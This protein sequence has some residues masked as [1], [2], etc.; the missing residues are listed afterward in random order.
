M[1][2]LN[3]INGELVEPAG[4]GWLE[5]VEPATGLVY[6]RLP[7]SDERDVERA[8]SA[9]CEAFGN[10]SRTPPAARSRV[11]VRLADLIE[12]NL[13]DLARAESI[14]T[15]K[16]LT[17]ARAV[18]I[19]RAAANLRFFATA[20]LHQRSDLHTSD[21]GAPA[22]Q[23][24][25]ALNYTLRQPLGAVG[26][27]SPWNL[28]LYLFTW[29]VAPALAAGNT[30][31]GKPSEL[32]PATAHRL[33]EMA[34]EAGLP[35][36]VLNI[37]HGLGPKTGAAITR[38]PAISAISFTGGTA[39]GAQVA[40]EVSPT[41]R[42]LSLELGG[43]N[44]TIVFADADLKAALAGSTLA[45]FAN[46]G[47][48]CLCGSRILVEQPIYESFLDGL[49]ERARSLRV[50]D[51]LCDS[52]KVG[53]LVSAAHLAKVAGYLDLA[54]REGGAVHCGGPVA[55]DDL[56]PRCR[57]GF[58]FAPAVISGL[59]PD[60]RT[61]CEEIFGPIVTVQPFHDETEA[62]EMANATDY[63]L[64]ASVWTR[65]V[66]RAHRVAE[67]VEAGTVWINCWL[68]RDLRV[69]FGGV[70]KSGV[71]REGGEEALRFFTEAKNVCVALDEESTGSARS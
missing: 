65:H 70:K 61:N 27:I 55:P 9:A 36:G 48:I 67:R 38:H 71:G 20:I 5:N 12:R 59:G 62:V 39:T 57:G 25:R 44:P 28:P 23:G 42:K 10:W 19:P 63:G 14:D 30:V 33:A 50:D 13:D 66:G 47:Q 51:P 2:V 45:A 69:P 56:P 46:Q 52:T 22:S 15:G 60:C 40:R 29:K 68:R 37:V 7:D 18:D 3:Y 53:S 31:V 32:T 35:P 24:G 26:C 43:K 17:L 21:E 64:S 49:V 58:F 54:R 8:V 4:G 11:L 16:P 6:G 34:V 1:D 41:F